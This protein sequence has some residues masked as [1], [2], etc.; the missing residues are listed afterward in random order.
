MKTVVLYTI[1]SFII[2]VALIFVL[3]IVSKSKDVYKRQPHKSG[4]NFSDRFSIILK[5]DFRSRAFLNL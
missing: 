1:I 4:K 2:L 5:V 3:R